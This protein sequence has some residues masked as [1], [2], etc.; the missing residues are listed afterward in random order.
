LTITIALAGHKEGMKKKID[1]KL[2][3]MFCYFDIHEGGFFCLR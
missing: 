1:E 2:P 3:A